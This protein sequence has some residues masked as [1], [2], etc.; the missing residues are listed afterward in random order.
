MI[1]EGIS[2]RS[3]VILTL[4]GLLDVLEQALSQQSVFDG[5]LCVR[6][7]QR[8]WELNA[9]LSLSTRPC[10][11]HGLWVIMIGTNARTIERRDGVHDTRLIETAP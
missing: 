4:T 1:D 6:E 7:I 2:A 5:R 10:Q 3:A 8:G 11:R 9:E